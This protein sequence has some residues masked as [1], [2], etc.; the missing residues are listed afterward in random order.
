MK[1]VKSEQG[2][3]KFPKESGEFSIVHKRWIIR[4]IISGRMTTQEAID[5]F[6]FQSKDPRSLLKYWRKRY[7]PQ[8][9]VSLPVMTEKERLKQEI[10]LKRLK[11][12]EKQLEDAQMKNIALETL[13][14]VAEEQLKIAIR[15]KA[16]AKQ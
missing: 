7:A 6:D 10:L 12:L 4:E 3:E 9:V 8:I 16:G 5:R 15:K 2:K 11:Q 13:I 1:E 14:D